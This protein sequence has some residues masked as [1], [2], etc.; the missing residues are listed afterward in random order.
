MSLYLINPSI[1]WARDS[2]A[3]GATR[4]TAYFV[5][6]FPAATNQLGTTGK[7]ISGQSV[8]S[9]PR[10]ETIMLAWQHGV[11]LIHGSN[12]PGLSSND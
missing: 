1:S 9:L 2:Q 7:K 6:K 5:I 12:L 4:S 8:Q 10:H 3:A 11:F